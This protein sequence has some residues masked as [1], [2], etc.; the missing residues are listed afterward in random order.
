MIKEQEFLQLNSILKS[1][2]LD[3]WIL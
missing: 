3:Y 2:S 1:N